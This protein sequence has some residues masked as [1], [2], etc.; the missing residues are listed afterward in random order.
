[1]QKIVI[2]MLSIGLSLA[3]PRSAARA[4]E[5]A[6]AAP[7]A[8]GLPAITVTEARLETLRDRVIAS[9]LIG[10]VEEVQVQP[11]IEGQPL[12][13]LLVEVGDVVT[14][15][16][17]L[18][19]LSKSTLELQRSEA[20]AS[21]A[22]GQATIAQAEAQ[23][24]EAEASAAEAQRVADRTAKLRAQGSSPQAAADTA[25]ANAVSAA[26]RVMVARQ[27]LEAARAQLALA[28]A[29]LENVDLQLSR[30]EVKAPVAGEIVERNARI[31]GIATAAGEAMFVIVRDSAL[32]LR[33]D[34]AE[35]DLLRLQVGQKASLRAVGGTGP[36]SGTV[37]LVEPRIDTVTRLGRARIE[38]DAPEGLRS[39]MYVEAEILVV[40][41][42]AL[43]VPVTAVGSDAT[44]ATVMR[45]RD[46]LV[47]RVPVRTGIRDGARVEIV[48]GLAVGDM[49]VVK[50]GAFV[51]AGDRIN[52]VP[53][54]AGTN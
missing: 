4:E 44:G 15:G 28:N 10:P 8:T 24:I 30:T 52:P 36:L 5:D 2:L 17:I 1:M 29:R 23:L 21:L 34:I 53:D 47:D 49:V 9:G 41:R 3:L 14:E 11:L 13:Q 25:N 46:G 7:V 18:A 35:G 20:V 26:A 31:G 38:V 50:A 37:R 43:S 54:M 12:E 45:V 48:E 40:E 32:E 42:A 51:R 33:A 39:G 22:S 27:T 6:A 16:Q 19:V